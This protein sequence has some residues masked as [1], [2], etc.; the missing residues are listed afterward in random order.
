MDYSSTFVFNQVSPGPVGFPAAYDSLGRS[1]LYNHGG[2]GTVTL[3]NLGADASFTLYVYSQRD[4]VPSETIFT[5][6]GSVQ[7]TNDIFSDSFL[8]GSNYLVFSG[9]ADSNGDIAII[10]RQSDGAFEATLNGF[11]LVTTAVP[12]PDSLTLLTLALASF[13]GLALI[14]KRI[15]GSEECNIDFGKGDKSN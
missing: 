12:E 8:L 10:F 6:N 5:V 2:Y 15:R 11:Q 13:G 9:T 14:T 3:H 4:Y 7:Q 1:Y